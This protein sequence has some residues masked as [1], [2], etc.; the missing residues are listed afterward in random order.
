MEHF[1]Y[2]TG[3][4]VALLLQRLG[5]LYIYIMQTLL[6]HYILDFSFH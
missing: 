4:M 2:P 3:T 1:G 6:L 5:N